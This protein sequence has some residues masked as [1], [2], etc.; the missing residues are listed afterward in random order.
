MCRVSG[1]SIRMHDGES[2]LYFIF[3]DMT[4]ERMEQNME[5]EKVRDIIVEVLSVD[6]ADITEETSFKDD[7]TADS[8]DIYQIIMGIEEAFEIVIP[9]EEAENIT[10][11]GDAVEKIKAAIG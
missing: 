3:S 10:T 1:A 5:F 8:L 6:P 7:L 11:V 9:A 4:T 2:Y